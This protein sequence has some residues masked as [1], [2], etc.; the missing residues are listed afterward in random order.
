[1][2]PTISLHRIASVKLT[3]VRFF[4]AAKRHD[5]STSEAFWS[6]ALIVTDKAGDTFTIDL[7]TGDG[8]AK[9]PAALLVD[10]LAEVAEKTKA[11]IAA[12]VAAEDAEAARLVDKAR[13][14]STEPV[15]Y[16]DGTGPVGT[17]KYADDE[18][19]ASIPF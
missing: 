13:A 15:G 3:P 19:A 5:G 2:K 9:S 18:P 16:C 6:R 4:P 17:L 7:Y 12:Q 11:D 14:G 1:M 10:G 8:S